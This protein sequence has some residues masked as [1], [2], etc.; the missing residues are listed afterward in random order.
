[1]AETESLH[2]FLS[3]LQK[4]ALPVGV[5]A[6]AACF[7]GAFLNPGQ[8][9]QSYLVAFLFWVG[10]SLGCLALLMLHHLVGGGWGFIIRRLLEA[11]SRTVPLMVVLFIPIVLGMHDLYIWTHPS[12]VAADRALQDKHIYL[13]TP[14]FLIR[15][16]VYF[17]VWMGFAWLLS[18]WSLQQDRTGDAS[19]TRR[20]QLLSGPGLVIYGI[21]VTFASIDWVMSLEPHWFSTIYGMIFMVG[22]VLSTLAI[23]ILLVVKLSDRSPIGDVMSP[24]YL[25]DLG[26]LLLAFVMLW[27]YVSFSQYLIIW[28]GNLTDEIPWYVQR[29][30]TGWKW[31]ALVLVVF[32]FALPFTLLLSRRIKR[33]VAVLSAIAGLMVI[34]RLVDLFWFVAP[35]FAGH[36]TGA[37]AGGVH[38]HWMDL[39]APIGIGG[40][41][42]W[43][44]TRQ[45]EGKALMPLHDPRMAE[46]FASSGEGH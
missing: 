45:M 10:V 30:E 17:L 24:R 26:T 4:R 6:L 1:M 25:R 37:V 33:R 39:V 9:Y 13:N 5:I 2:P 22:Q 46:A 28:A 43:F 29:T 36:A 11:G 32:H 40:L 31:I 7:G 15:A 44:F 20:M 3:R 38:V 16:A 35:A 21:T 19:L 42:L 12:V 41:W 27:A 14:F 8:F 18:R 34:M 23:A